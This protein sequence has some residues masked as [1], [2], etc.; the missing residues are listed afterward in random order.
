MGVKTGIDYP[1][2]E[3]G[4]KSNNRAPDLLI[5][6][7]I[8]Q[9]DTYTPLQ[10]SQY[11]STIANKGNRY[12]TRFLKATKDGDGT[13]Y[14]IKPVKLNTLD[15]NKKYINRVRRGLRLVMTGGTGVGYMNMAPTP[16]GKTGTSESLVDTDGDGIMDTETISNNFV[17]YAPSNRPVMTITG[18]FPDIAKVTSNDYKSNANMRMISKATKIFFGLYDKNGK[19]IVKK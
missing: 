2:E 17:G 5:N 12:K 16:S 18:A 9:Y 6:F 15:V 11:I 14:N 19:K 3:D 4:Y 8:G 7:A 10:L 13:I 1:K